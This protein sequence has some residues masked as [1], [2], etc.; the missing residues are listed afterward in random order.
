MGG[1]TGA[2]RLLVGRR[3]GKRPFGTPRCGWESNIKIDLQ[4]VGWGGMD[5]ID[6]AESRDRRRALVNAAMNMWVP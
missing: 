3:E 4:E 1:R 6:L 5:W 2:N